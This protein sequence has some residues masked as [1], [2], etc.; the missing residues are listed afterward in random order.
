MRGLSKGQTLLVL[1]TPEVLCLVS[2]ATAASPAEASKRHA[3]LQ[4]EL[5]SSS[6]QGR[7]LRAASGWLVLNG[8][9]SE[10]IQFNLLNEQSL[11]NVFRKNAY[12]ML[13]GD[14]RQRVGSLA[15]TTHDRKCLDVFRE[16]LDYT[17]ENA[18]HASQMSAR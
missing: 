11:R 5:Q 6:G 8:M 12:R 1:M 2:E 10:K 9:R 16:R 15:A 13:C 4:S 17:I 7:I 18:I 3:E 14:A